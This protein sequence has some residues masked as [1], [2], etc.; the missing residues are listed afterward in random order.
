MILTA[1]FVIVV[2]TILILFFGFV[3]AAEEDFKNDEDRKS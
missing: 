1:L 2:T 3:D